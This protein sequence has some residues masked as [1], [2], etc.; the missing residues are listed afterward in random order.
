MEC[1]IASGVLPALFLSYTSVKV[2]TS[3]AGKERPFCMSNFCFEIC[4]SKFYSK[5]DVTFANE[6]IRSFFKIS[7]TKSV[8]VRLI[9]ESGEKEVRM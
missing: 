3:L 1:D 2:Y 9:S 5:V 8:F 4:T 7:V 6:E